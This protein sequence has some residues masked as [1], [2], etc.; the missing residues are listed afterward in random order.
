MPAIADPLEHYKKMQK[1]H[2]KE[3]SYNASFDH[4]GFLSQ[5]KERTEEREHTED[6]QRSAKCSVS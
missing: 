3:I 5:E 4:L 2:S 1:L 6:R